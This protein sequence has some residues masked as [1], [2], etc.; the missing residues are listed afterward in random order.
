[1][2]QLIPAILAIDVEPDERQI[3]RPGMAEWTGFRALYEFTDAFWTELERT[4]GR[5]PRFGWFLRMDPQIQE[6]HGA[7]DFVLTYFADRFE[8]LQARGDYLGLH[9][10]ASRWSDDLGLWVTDLADSGWVAHCI[11]ASFE[12]YTTA[13]GAPPARHRFG[14]GFFSNRI[15]A[16][17]T[18]LGAQVDL[19]LEPGMDYST[20]GAIGPLVGEPADFREVPRAPYRPSPDDYQRPDARG[21][22]PL[23]LIPLTARTVRRNG[24]LL[25]RTARSV[26]W[27]FRVPQMSLHLW[28][29]WSTPT[30]Y[31]DAVELHLA[32]MEQPYLALLVRTDAASSRTISSATSLLS[33]LLRH[34]LARRLQFVDALELPRILGT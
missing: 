17:I 9:V 31:W 24:S 3:P 11:D 16:Q 6:S 32:A 14:S 34:R 2:P 12:A 4:S 5:E 25:R 18:S 30:A 23:V 21:A 15:A 26:K 10:H 28:R 8:H 22:N 1:M 33:A 7:A 27:R 13:F 29:Q 20:G 19:T